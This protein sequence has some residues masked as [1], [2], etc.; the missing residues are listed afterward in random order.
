[1]SPSAARSSGSTKKKTTDRT[2][3]APQKGSGRAKSPVTRNPMPR[4]SVKDSPKASPRK[5]KFAAAVEQK[6][7]TAGRDPKPQIAPPVPEPIPVMPAE[8]KKRTKTEKSSTA[9]AD[10]PK[11]A[12]LPAVPPVEEAAVSSASKRKKAAKS[13]PTQVIAA[14]EAAAERS[15]PAPSAATT[16][17]KR[18]AKSKSAEP[19]PP[20]RPE[21]DEDEGPLFGEGKLSASDEDDEPGRDAAETDEFF[22]PKRGRGGR[23][24]RTPRAFDAD[25]DF[26]E[27][28]DDDLPL[29]DEDELNPD[30]IDID[31][32]DVP[33]E[34]LDP[35]LV[36]VPRPAL[37]PKPKPK[38]PRSERRQ[39][40]CDGCGQLYG[41]LSVEKLCFNCLKK[42]LSQRKSPDENYSSGGFSGGGGGESDD[43]DDDM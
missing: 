32:L 37:P 41:W 6:K 39:Q 5:P 30:A 36:E 20:A 8:N 21:R 43:G 23:G 16:P 14:T 12:A 40:K 25:N 11:S 38:P 34:L 3:Q 15:A 42:K 1:M 19:A 9:K 29:D 4:A 27:A 18:A 13:E 24:G 26:L 22:E 28:L 10:K 33:L 31:P 35:E 17:R 2:P 7:V